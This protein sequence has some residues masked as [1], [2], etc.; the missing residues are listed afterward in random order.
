ML[1]VPFSEE[2]NDLQLEGNREF[3]LLITILSV[4]IVLTLVFYFVYIF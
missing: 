4:H 1:S 2:L 3:N